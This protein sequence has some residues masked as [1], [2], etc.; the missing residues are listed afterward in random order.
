MFV[1]ELSAG[2][3]FATGVGVGVLASAIALVVT[4]IIYSKKKK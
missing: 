4:A 2:A 3:I 1:F